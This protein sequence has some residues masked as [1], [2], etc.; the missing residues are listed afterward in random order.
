MTPLLIVLVVVCVGVLAAALL[1][2]RGRGL[3]GVALPLVLFWDKAQRSL[4]LATRSLWLHKLRAFLSVL[5]IIIGTGAVIALMGL[6]EGSMHDALEDIKRQGATN[7]IIKSQKPPDDA[8]S[9]RRAFVV[10]YGLT[11][12]DYERFKILTRPGPDGEEP[13]VTRMVPMR[14]FPQE[15]RRHQHMHNGRVVG[16]SWRYQEVNQFAVLPG[17]RFLVEKDEEELADVAVLGSTVAEALFPFESALGK[18]VVLGRHDYTVVGVLDDRL[19]SG[20]TGAGAEEFNSDVYIPLTTCRAR[21]GERIYI[22]ASGSRSAEQVELHQVTLTVGNMDQVRAVGAVISDQL[23]GTHWKKDWSL[24]I[25]LDRLEEAER[26]RD[27]YTM[28]LA[29]IAFI[30]L[31]VGGIGI[32]NI[33]LATVTER[34]REIGIRRALGAKRRDITLQ[35]LVEALVQ[36][37]LGG[38]VGVLLGLLIVFGVPWLADV[39]FNHHL[40]ARLHVLSIFLAL[41]VTLLIGVGFGLYPAFRASRL[42]PI[43]ALRHE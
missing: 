16:T 33:M 22:R 39:L 3:R 28:L 17:G 9:Q 41:G 20:G 34:T 31:F 29:W 13:P 10:S 4:V 11:Y 8:L 24:T 37:S 19:P 2:A 6:G 15:I 27:R 21:F 14:I 1:L 26:A 36:T 32:M 35:F 40:P 42:D 18:T 43:E 30:S 12:K 25:P 23:Q 7:I 5:G 38:V